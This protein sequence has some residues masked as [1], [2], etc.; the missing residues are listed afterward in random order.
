MSWTGSGTCYH[1]HRQRLECGWPGAGQKLSKHPKIT[2]LQSS[3]QWYPAASRPV[4]VPR[5]VNLTGSSWDRIQR[6]DVQGQHAGASDSASV[7]SSALRWGKVSDA[8][9]PIEAQEGVQ[10]ELQACAW[11]A[12]SAAGEV[13]RWDSDPRLSLEV[14]SEPYR[15]LRTPSFKSGG[16]LLIIGGF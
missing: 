12:R 9:Y 6:D 11:Y 1:S 2:K 15:F 8:R 7:G 13:Q 10:N 3:P 4:S 16:W 14:C 5:W